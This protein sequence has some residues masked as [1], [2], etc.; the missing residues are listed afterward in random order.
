MRDART[1]VDK[2][3]HDILKRLE[4]I[5][6]LGVIDVA[7]ILAFAEELNATTARY[8]HILAQEQGRRKAHH[9]APDAGD[10]ENP[11]EEQ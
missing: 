7:P 3:Y 6:L 11:V 10:D 5:V 1:P 9:D 2:A 4:A 8:K